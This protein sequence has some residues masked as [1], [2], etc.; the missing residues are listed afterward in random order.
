M[1]FDK[2]DYYSIP[3]YLQKFY[4]TIASVNAWSAVWGSRSSIQKTPLLL[5]VLVVLSL[6]LIKFLHLSLLQP[7]GV[8]RV[9][10]IYRLLVLQV[11]RTT[12]SPETQEGSR[13]FHGSIR[14]Y[15]FKYRRCQ[16]EFGRVVT[17]VF[18]RNGKKDELVG[19]NSVFL[20]S[21]SLLKTIT[22]VS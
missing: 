1:P 13:A 21:T 5:L 20:F 10:Y 19:S 12:F 2:P 9:I 17:A 18:R 14:N 6:D 15:K 4:P 3:Y 11:K 8:G 16:W 7:S 22:D